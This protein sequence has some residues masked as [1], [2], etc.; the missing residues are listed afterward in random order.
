M[1]D[2]LITIYD[3]NDANNLAEHLYDTQGLG[4]LSDWLTATVSNK[5]NGAE[6]FQ[7]TYPISGTNADLIIEG[8]II[9]C[10]V[11]ENRAKQRLRIYY[12]KTSVIGNTIEVKAE[13]IFND[14]RKS[15][16]NKYDSGTE[17]ITATQAWQNAKALAKP[18]IPPQFSFSSL[19]DTLANVKIEKANFLEFFGGKEGSILDRFHCEFLKD[20]NTLRHEKRL[21]TDHK[22][23][24]IYTKNLT[25]LDLEI[26]A[27]SVLVGI[28]PF[29]S[30]SSEGEDEIT[31][32]EEVI[33]TDYVDDYPAGY[34][35]FVDF[36]DKATDVATLREVAKD[37]LKT[38]IDKQ[39]PQV[40]GSI[41]L[42]PLRDQRG[43]EKFVDLE[44]VSMGD[45]VDV[46]HPQLKVNM[47]ARIVEYTF[48]VLT[49]SYDK[50]VVGNVKTNFLE[51]TENNVSNLINDA[52]D[53]LKNGGEIS[54][55][56]NDIV[57]HQTDM[58]TGQNGGY[59]LLDPKEAPSRI[60]IMDTPDKTTARNVLQIN[61]AGIG[62]SKTGINGTYETAWT[63]DGGFNASFITAGE[64]VGITIRGT[65]LISDG[66]DYR[67]S[68]ANGK[69]TWYS[70]KVNKDIMELEARDYVS[71]DAGIVSYTMKT[72][73]GFMIRNPQGNLVFSTWDNGNNRPFLSFGAPNF[74]YS[75]ASYIN[76]GDGNS[77]GIDGSAGNSWEF[78]VAGRTMKF[79]SDGM[80]TLPGCFFGSWED[81]KLARFEQS[82]VQV[83]KDFTVRGTKNS[84]VP[85]EHYGQRLLNAYET[86]EYYFADYGEAVTGDDGKVRV[87]IDP[88][89]A[90]TVNL[91]RYM[92][93]VTP[94]ELVLCAVTHEDVDHFIIETSKPNVLVRWN[95][96]AH[97]LGYEDIRLKEDTAYDS[98]VLDQKRF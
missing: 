94:T 87:D 25:G 2:N 47:S 75:N 50:L 73:G 26:D 44:K 8:R 93:H 13:P 11:D 33:F 81:G 1:I 82:T 34:V 31:L 3:K 40:S 15:V 39:K 61:N 52:I 21:G 62:F 89:F 29:I 10:Y 65:T 55:L 92:T 77:L 36:K 88:M 14:I 83:Y 32:P 16:L 72:G 38:N 24:A 67:T 46:Y 12:A 53:Q 28:Y 20:N 97:R 69:M 51:N 23:K 5:L 19:V 68:I 42:V 66:T 80:L 9:Q 35:S 63:L 57:D 49:N 90:E 6:I 64:I 98:T 91:S 96:V 30:S 76:D 4:A 56:I 22:I 85:T 86:P 74:R 7:G 78:K 60:L 84:T 59:V 37:W 45:G 27:Q 95:L 79:T 48:N 71:A 58:I 70:K 43:Y 18:A 41:E 17:K 54:D